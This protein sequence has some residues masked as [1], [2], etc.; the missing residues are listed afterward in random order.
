MAEPTNEHGE[1]PSTRPER[2]GPPRSN[3]NRS[4]NQRSNAGGSQNSRSNGQRSNQNRSNQN[5]SRN[6]RSK[7]GANQNR[8]NQNRSGSQQR[9]S[10]PREKAVSGIAVH[11]EATGGK[12]PL[13]SERVKNLRWPI[14]ACA[15]FGSVIGLIVI[16]VTFWITLPGA[17]TLGVVTAAILFFFFKSVAPTTLKNNLGSVVIEEGA[18]P[19]VEVMLSGLSATMGV[20]MPQIAI[21]DDDIPNAAIYTLKKTNTLVITTGLLSSMSVIELEGV[22]AHELAHLRLESAVRGTTAAGLALLLGSF[23]RKGTLSHRMMGEGR[24][25]R[26]DALAAQTVRYSAGLA[27]A[28][29]KMEQGPLP[30]EH[31]IFAS[32]VY[33]S[34]RWIFIDP[35][36]TRR[37]KAEEIGDLDATSTRRQALE[38]R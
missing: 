11:A 23:G 26:A 12:T 22:L 25:Y 14:L 4:K 32:P 27:S 6:N 7:G 15:V 36:I 9:S 30:G 8:S 17:V 29:A 38:E 13:D 16:L 5:R 31:S 37:A 21:L 1:S 24:L 28:L 20:A 10:A 33:K 35:S 34:I 19:R 18:L 3:Q 2:S